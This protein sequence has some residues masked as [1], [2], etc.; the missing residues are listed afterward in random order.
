MRD[1]VKDAYGDLGLAKLQPNCL[2]K[3]FNPSTRVFILRV[4]REDLQ[5]A[6]TSLALMTKVCGVSES[7]I[8]RVRILHVGGTLEKVEKAMKKMT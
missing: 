6:E 8:G 1:A 5:T 3:Y 2:V 7:T 4:A